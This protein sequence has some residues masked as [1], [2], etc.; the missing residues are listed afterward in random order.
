M[1]VFTYKDYIKC[2]HTL[3]L[4]AVFQLAEE[5]TEYNLETG[6][7]KKNINHIHE[8]INNELLKDKKEI[9]NLINDFV[10]IDNKIEEGQLVKYTNNFITRKYKSRDADVIYKLK[11]KSVFFLIEHQTSIDN[12][13]VYKMLNYCVDIIYDWNTSVKIKK[14]IKYP[15]VVPIVIYTGTDKWNIS[16]DFSDMQVGDYVFKNYKIDFKYNLIEINKIPLKLLVQKN[17]LFSHIM[18]LEKTRNYEEFT[19]VLN[20]VLFNKENFNKKFYDISKLLLE[21]LINDIC[22]G[23]NVDFK[24]GGNS[25]MSSLYE[26]QINGFRQDIKNWINESKYD[27]KKDVVKNLIA[28]NSSDEFITKITNIT[29]K[30]LQEMKKE[31]LVN[32]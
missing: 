6:K 13:I 21:N 5:G 24:I 3:R 10:S 22:K 14:G 7:P 26:R 31:L 17:D 8:K 28:N 2:I 23:E 11:D 20:Q 27:V 4:N 9:V 15:I 12:N 29:K 30:E 25:D 16:N 18:A 32:K 1:E 19:N